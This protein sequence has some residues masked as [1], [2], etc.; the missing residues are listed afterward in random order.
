MLALLRITIRG[1]VA[2]AIISG[3][4]TGIDEHFAPCTDDGG[5]A[6]WSTIADSDDMPA[7]GA[8]KTALSARLEEGTMHDNVQ[9][10]R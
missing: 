3:K 10:P 9:P 1:Q 7:S 8:G 2:P 5:A 4:T 6:A